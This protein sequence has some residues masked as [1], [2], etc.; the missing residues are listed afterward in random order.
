MSKGQGGGWCGRRIQRTDSG[1]WR[2]GKS[3]RTRRRRPSCAQVSYP[4]KPRVRRTAGKKGI[5]ADGWRGW[6][7]PIDS[8]V[9]S[10]EPA[11]SLD[12]DTIACRHVFLMGGVRQTSGRHRQLTVPLRTEAERC[13]RTTESRARRRWSRNESGLVNDPEENKEN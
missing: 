11:C 13:G 9:G 3:G 12:S 5:I 6:I 7:V 2:K 1:G 4:Q 8:S 10:L